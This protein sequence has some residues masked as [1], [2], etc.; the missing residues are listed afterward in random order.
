[1]KKSIIVLSGFL[2]LFSGCVN[3][4]SNK[5][6][7]K[8]STD[9]VEKEVKLSENLPTATKKNKAS[10]EPIKTNI[11]IDTSTQKGVKWTN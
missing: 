6:V 3:S 9:T 4:D 11:Q 8:K 5:T 10:E 1:M 7:V 2:L